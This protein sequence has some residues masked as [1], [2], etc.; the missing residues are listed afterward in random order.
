MHPQIGEADERLTRRY[1]ASGPHHL[2]MRMGQQH[3]REPNETMECW[4]AS[5]SGLGAT[6][7][8]EYWIDGRRIRAAGKAPSRI[9]APS[10]DP[11]FFV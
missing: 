10:V 3:A 9:R 7:T 2:A 6:T 5:Y 8:P 1:V 11:S 4:V